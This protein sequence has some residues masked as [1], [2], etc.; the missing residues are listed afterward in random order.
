MLKPRAPKP[1]HTT[2]AHKYTINNATSLRTT[3]QMH[4]ASKG[5]PAT[6]ATPKET[7]LPAIYNTMPPQAT[8]AVRQETSN[9]LATHRPR[10][11]PAH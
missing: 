4:K 9:N 8:A 6:K 11:T 2:H 5:A 1:S 7:P 3:Y 10:A